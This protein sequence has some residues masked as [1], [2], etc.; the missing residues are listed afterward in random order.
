MSNDQ[1]KLLT[2]EQI[3]GKINIKHH[4]EKIIANKILIENG[5]LDEKRDVLIEEDLNYTQI[6]Y[7]LDTRDETYDKAIN[8]YNVVNYYFL[9]GQYDTYA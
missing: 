4:L 5:I 2:N 6:K 7:L 3:N 9:L 8:K 1:K